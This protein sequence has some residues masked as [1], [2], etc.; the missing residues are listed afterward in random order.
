MS[1]SY[2]GGKGDSDRIKDHETYGKNHDN[3]KSTLKP[4]RVWETE[5]SIK[6]REEKAKRS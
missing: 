1:K 2:Q 4:K 3:L 6:R 5:A